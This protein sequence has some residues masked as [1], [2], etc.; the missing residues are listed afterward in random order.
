MLPEQNH[1]LVLS[2]QDY[3]QVTFC[4]SKS[5]ELEGNRKGITAVLP[6]FSHLIPVGLLIPASLPSVSFPLACCPVRIMLSSVDGYVLISVSV[7]MFYKVAVV[8]MC[9]SLC[10]ICGSGSWNVLK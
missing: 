9:N 4:H 5:C 10:G 6:Q 1:L 8:L 2:K 7:K 3:S